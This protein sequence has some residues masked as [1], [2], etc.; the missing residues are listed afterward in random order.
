MSGRTKDFIVPL[1]DERKRHND[2]GRRLKVA[3]DGTN[4]GNGFAKPHFVG[5]KSSADSSLSN[6][7]RV[8]FVF[9]TPFYPL[10]LMRFFLHFGISQY[11]FETLHTGSYVHDDFN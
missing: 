4:H 3:K 7:S 5:D 11:F 2:E 1:P 6:R 9:Q 10:K 8:K